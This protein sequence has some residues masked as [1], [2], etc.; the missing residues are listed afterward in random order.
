MNKTDK[1]HDRKSMRDNHFNK[2]EICTFLGITIWGITQGEVT[3]FYLI[4]LFWFQ[5]LIRTIINV[6]Y[7]FKK[8]D[9][10]KDESGFQRA[11]GNFFILFVYFIFI[12][13]LFGFMLNWNKKELLFANM[14]IL[15]FR[16]LYFDLT[17]FLF[18]LQYLIYRLREEKNNFDLGLFN[19][20]HI[21]LYLSIIIG[22][23]IQLGFVKQF[24]EYFSGKELWGAALV[25]L[26][27]LL[28]KIFLGNKSYRSTSGEAKYK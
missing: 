26:P 25:A 21:V 10:V 1:N 20:N 24:P 2:I 27:F 19:K 17:V 22:A 7:V 12:V 28:L 11:Y 4:Y 13:L 18:A 23:L 5:E 15:L 9:K 16:N 6:F 14:E 3:V 8:R